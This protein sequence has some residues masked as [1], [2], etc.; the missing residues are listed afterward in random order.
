MTCMTK[1]KAKLPPL[2]DTEILKS[3]SDKASARDYETRLIERFRRMYGQETLPG[4][5]T[6]R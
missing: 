2:V 3:F 5:L 1:N 6:N 4:N